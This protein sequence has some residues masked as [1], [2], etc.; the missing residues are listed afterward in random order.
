MVIFELETQRFGQL[1]LLKKASYRVC[2]APVDLS[3]TGNVIA[4]ADLMKSVSLVEYTR[5]ENG[6]PDSL[7]EVARHFR[8]S[9][10]TAVANVGED[11]YL[12][13]DAEGNLIVLHRNIN[14]VTN[15]DKRKLEVV[16]EMRL[17]EMVNRIRRINVP[18]T[19]GA[20]V[21]P[22]AFLATVGHADTR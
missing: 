10:A 4:V 15:D 14:G 22:R 3:V 5:G 8:V 9:W 6:M 19:P 1:N 2:T 17:G 12:Q 20:A 11:T 7:N 16:S 13:S 21:I 18:L